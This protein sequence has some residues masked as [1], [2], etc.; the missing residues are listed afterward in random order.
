MSIQVF[1]QEDYVKVKEIAK[2]SNTIVKEQS[3]RR[4]HVKLIKTTPTKL[5]SIL[6]YLKYDSGTAFTNPATIPASIVLTSNVS[7]LGIGVPNVK[8]TYIN[9]ETGK[10][11]GYGVTD[12]LGNTSITIN[13]KEPGEMNIISVIGENTPLLGVDIS[14]LADRSLIAFWFIAIRA[15]PIKDRWAR[16]IGRSIDEPLPYRFWKEKPRTVLGILGGR[17][18]FSDLVAVANTSRT[19]EIGISAYC[20]TSSPTP[21]HDECCANLAWWK[22]E[23]FATKKPREAPSVLKGET[24]FVGSDYINLD[25][26]IKL[27]ISRDSVTFAGR[28]FINQRCPQESVDTRPE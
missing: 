23:V 20:D 22:V 25:Y 27:N 8:I 1:E 14:P 3:P 12:E 10:R 2:S 28:T 4:F 26:H 17:V 16:Y 15:T 6:T 18:V 9:E 11:V 21:S 24:G 13:S 19:Y 5:T 7:V